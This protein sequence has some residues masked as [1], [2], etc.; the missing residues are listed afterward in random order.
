M[1][2]I[3][4]AGESCEV[5]GSRIRDGKGRIGKQCRE[6]WHNH[7][8]P[9]IKKGAW[10][11]EEDRLILDAHATLGN[12]VISTNALGIAHLSELTHRVFLVGRNSKASPRTNGQLCQ[13]SLEFNNAA[14][15]RKQV[16]KEYRRV[17]G[18][19]GC[20]CRR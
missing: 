6:R 13:K 17:V 3:F 14:E 1:R 16:R 19:C 2:D 7:L 12:K 8:H 18:T 20:G 10:S 4:E 5:G 9:G 11:V 15:K